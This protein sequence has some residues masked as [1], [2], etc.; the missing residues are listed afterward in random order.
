MRQGRRQ[1][2]AKFPKFQ[3]EAR[4]EKIPDPQAESTFLSEKLRWD[5]REQPE[6]AG[7]EPAVAGVLREEGG[8]RDGEISP[9]AVRWSLTRTGSG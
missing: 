1:E 2:F 3:D 7:F 6:H 8:G 5:E 9:W 4:R